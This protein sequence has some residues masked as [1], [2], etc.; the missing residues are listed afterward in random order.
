MIFITG[1]NGLIGSFVIRQF[2]EQGYAVRA[3][4]RVNSDLSLLADITH[5]I[6]WVEGDLLDP[7]LLHQTIQPGDIVIHAAAIVSFSAREYEKMRKVNVEGTANV[8]NVCLQR[9][10]KKFCFV[11]SI[12][13]LGRENHFHSIDEST[14]WEDSELNTVYA[15]SKYL[16]ELEVWRGEAEGLPAV[17]VNPSVVLGPGDWRRSSTQLFKYAWDEHWFYPA[18]DEFCG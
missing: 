13:A 14:K 6:Q 16:A 8:V 5:R 7:L 3:L 1:S 11:S 10:V 2:I 18:G 15:Q 4:R 17:I 12:A 9:G